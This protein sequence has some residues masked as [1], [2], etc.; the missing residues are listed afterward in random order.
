MKSQAIPTSK[1]KTAH[2]LLGEV[3]RIILAE[4]LRYDQTS[5]LMYVDPKEKPDRYPACGT[6]GCVAG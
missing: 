2:E 6:V 3:R 1:A 4:P 5:T